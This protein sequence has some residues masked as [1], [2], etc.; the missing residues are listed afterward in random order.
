M[1]SHETESEDFEIVDGAGRVVGNIRV[2]PNGILWKSKGKH[3][4]W[5]VAMEKFAEF[6]EQNGKLQQ[7]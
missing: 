1:E 2:K 5:G 3:K 4:W 7:K 6:A